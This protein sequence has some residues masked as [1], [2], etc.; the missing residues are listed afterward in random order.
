[1][2][3]LQR[4]DV[5]GWRGQCSRSRVT[6]DLRCHRP[7]LSPPASV[8]RARGRFAVLPREPSGMRPTSGKRTCESHAGR[9]DRAAVRETRC[10]HGSSGGC[11]LDRPPD[12]GSSRGRSVGLRCLRRHVEGVATAAP[13]RL[14]SAPGRCAVATTALREPH[15]HRQ[16]VRIL[17]KVD[18]ERLSA[19]VSAREALGQGRDNCSWVMATCCSAFDKLET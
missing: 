15:E 9:G 18:R 14:P 5:S 6:Q 1:M 8:R 16:V 19:F 17:R 4:A 3:G 2:G 11:R 13:V 7:P 12:S 10:W